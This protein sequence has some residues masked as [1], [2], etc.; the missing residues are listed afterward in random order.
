M[1][2]DAK[3]PKVVKDFKP[4]VTR[5]D[6]LPLEAAL[7]LRIHGH[8]VQARCLEERLIAMYKSGHGYFWI[9]GPGEEAFNV[10][11]GLLIKKGCGPAFDYCH[12]H[13]R[14][15]ATFLTMGEPPVGAIRQMKN[16][17]GDPYSGGRNFA[18]HFSKRAWNLAPVTSP[19]E[20]QYVMAVGTAIAQRRLG[21]DAITIV[22]GGDAGTAEGD[23]ASCLVWASRPRQELPMLILVTNNHYGI[24]TPY[25]QVQGVARVSDR[26]AAFGMRSKTIDG[27]DPI[28]SYLELKEAFEYVRA[29]RKPY[30]V[31]ANVSRLHG[32]SSASGA[33]YSSAEPDCLALFEEKLIRHGLLTKQAA[34]ALREQ[35]S[36]ELADLARQAK[37]EPMPDG[38]EIWNH[39]YAGEPGPRPLPE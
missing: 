32:H 21:G 27:N 5:S 3:K 26:A 7:L 24:S 13:Y 12:F 2:K 11:L 39:V 36:V 29:E 34:E 35:H 16:T 1:A 8:M 22:T 18:G 15:A 38:S 10:P 37:E 14:Q 30:L 33:N 23:F 20:V 6:E 25:A 28:S 31:E 17:R 9:G 4:L 19:I